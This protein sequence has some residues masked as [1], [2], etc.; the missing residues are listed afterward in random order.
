M[1]LKTNN[2]NTFEDG[3]EKLKEDRFQ[4]EVLPLQFGFSWRLRKLLAYTVGGR[5]NSRES[6]KYTYVFILFF[7]LLATAAVRKKNEITFSLI[8]WSRPFPHIVFLTFSHASNL[9]LLLHWL[10]CRGKSDSEREVN[11]LNVYQLSPVILG[12][13]SDCSVCGWYL[14]ICNSVLLHFISLWSFH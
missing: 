4:S 5:I 13:F 1:R 3:L 11:L 7:F 12:P 10:K 14:N 2:R 8:M 6:S 9:P